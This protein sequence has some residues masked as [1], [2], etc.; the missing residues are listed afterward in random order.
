MIKMEEEVYNDI[1]K[2]LP[3]YALYNKFNSEI[4]EVK[5]NNA[6]KI[7][8]SVTSEYKDNCI[9]L[10]KKVARNL[11]N[12]PKKDKSW[13]YENRCSHYK[14]W[15]YE[16]IRKFFKDDAKPNDVEVVI[17]EFLRVQPLLTTD[18]EIL[19]C[20]YKFSQKN[21]Q[22]LET[23]IEEKYMFDYFTN[24]EHIKA[25]ETCVNVEIEKYKKYLN[26]IL[27]LYNRKK[28][29]C[30]VGKISKCPNYFL[31]CDNEFNPS[32]LLSILGSSY[33]GNCNGL[34]S[35][36]ETKISE[37]KLESSDLEQDFL[38]TIHFTNCHIKNN[39]KELSCGFVRASALPRRNMIDVV[40]SGQENGE[41]SYS[42]ERKSVSSINSEHAALHEEVRK[43]VGISSK[44]K[45][46]L[47]TLKKNEE[48]DLRWNI[49]K[50]GTLRCT[51]EILENDTSGPCT[52][53]EELVKEGI[54]IKLENSSGYQLKK[55]KTWPP[56]AIKIVIKKKNQI[57]MKKYKSQKLGYPEHALIL[58]SKELR[59]YNRENQ[60][61]ETLLG[62]DAGT[63]VL[64][65]NFVRVSFVVTLV[66]GIIMVLF[67]Y[68]KF[69]IFG[70]YVGKIKNRKKRY[71]TNL[72][73]LNTQ[74]S[75]K[76][77][78]KRTYRNTNRRR[79]SVVNIE[80]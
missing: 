37:E 48:V 59:T 41:R 10:C 49:S 53:M 12:L 63:Y 74:R 52:Y 69:T 21:L 61:G 11:E 30:C 76:R 56:E 40:N 43:I 3:S 32:E 58:N 13:S 62:K 38:D 18:Y 20:D 34:E 22:E 14:Y 39:D 79:F 46:N 47:S 25:K 70:S 78:I 75:S 8:D 29:V 24:Y 17:K 80:Q 55:G 2:Q 50:D 45:N 5:Y 36:E 64:Q 68:F 77:Y 6:C 26:F 60:S 31:N 42:E 67:L 7:P 65:N 28:G 9:N 15:L 57:Q 44:K 1:L 19:N 4:K 66:M 72:A 35:F 73:D 16:E 54:F 51:S 27:Q 33:D 71:K 23:K